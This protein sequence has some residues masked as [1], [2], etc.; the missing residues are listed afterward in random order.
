MKPFM[1]YVLN[2]LTA[3]KNAYTSLTSCSI[4]F[5]RFEYQADQ[6]EAE[7]LTNTGALQVLVSKTIFMV[8]K[9]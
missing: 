2:H 5:V 1:R 6:N 4:S 9:L 7:A 3:S 8:K